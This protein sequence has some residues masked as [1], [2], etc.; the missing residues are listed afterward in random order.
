MID[1]RR[2]PAYHQA[3]QLKTPHQPVMNCLSPGSV[4]RGNSA[5][6]RIGAAVGLFWGAWER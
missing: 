6:N 2:E 4:P 3:A 1:Q 5:T